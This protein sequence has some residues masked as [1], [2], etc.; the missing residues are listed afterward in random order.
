MNRVAPCQTP[1]C[2]VTAAPVVSGAC[3]TWIRCPEGHE[4][5]LDSPVSKRA[6]IRL[7][8]ATRDR[9]ERKGWTAERLVDYF[10]SMATFRDAVRAAYAEVLAD[11]G[12]VEV[13]PLAYAL[14][15]LGLPDTAGNRTRLLVAQAGGLLSPEAKRLRDSA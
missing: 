9:D 14:A 7:I 11:A 3:G 12:I 8:C 5:H 2:P 10:D 13:D 6:R 15:R 1:G 4:H